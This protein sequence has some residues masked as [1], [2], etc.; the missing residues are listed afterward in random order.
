[1]IGGT[2]KIFDNI[3][4]VEMQAE[5][6]DRSILALFDFLIV[7]QTIARYKLNYY[8][9]KKYEINIFISYYE[10]VNQSRF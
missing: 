2:Q 5:K 6:V 4:V 10:L 8:L 9:F 1:M 3:K 7:D